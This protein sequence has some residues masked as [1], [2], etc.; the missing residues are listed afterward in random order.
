MLAA[1]RIIACSTSFIAALLCLSSAPSLAA[2]NKADGWAFALY[3]Q[4]VGAQMLARTCERAEPG[5]MARFAPRY[6]SWSKQN[7]AQIERGEQVYLE[8]LQNDP[9]LRDNPKYAQIET[10][11]KSLASPP[12]ADATPI[13]MSDQLRAV[14]ED[15]LN[16][17]SAR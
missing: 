13:A 8:S 4:G 11:R 7:A 1:S 6:A 17:V 9:K 5:Y 16:T 15:N 2:P 3:I 14:C 10:S 12:P